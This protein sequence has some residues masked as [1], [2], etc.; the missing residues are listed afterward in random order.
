MHADSSRDRRAKTDRARSH[1]PRGRPD[2]VPDL[3]LFELNWKP[4]QVQLWSM[5]TQ[6]T[7]YSASFDCARQIKRSFS[8]DVNHKVEHPTPYFLICGLA[9]TQSLVFNVIFCFACT[10]FPVLSWNQ[11][12]RPG[13]L[14]QWLLSSASRLSSNFATRRPWSSTSAAWGSTLRSKCFQA[15]K[16]ERSAV[17]F[18]DFQL[19]LQVRRPPRSS[20]DIQTQRL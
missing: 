2:S 17:L 20:C 7:L 6:N 14:V 18:H 8:S 4:L 13:P 10:P 15:G 3:C 16:G 11:P 1:S 19:V 12:A 5:D 9:T